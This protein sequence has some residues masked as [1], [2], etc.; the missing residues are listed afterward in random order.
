MSRR[1]KKLPTELVETT[2]ESLSHEGR[3][4]SHIDGKT[5][6]IDNALPGETVR[7]KYKSTRKKFDEGAAQEI[8]SPST[9]RVEPPCQHADMCGGCSLQHIETSFQIQ[10]KENML[11]EQLEHIGHVLP[12]SVLAPLT[13]PT[14]SYR[15]K[16]RLGVKYVVKKEKV[17]VGFREKRSSFLAD[18]DQ[19]EVLHPSVGKLITPLK[20]LITSLSIYNQIPQIEVAVGEKNTVLIFRELEAHTKEDTEKLKNFENEHNISIYIQ[21]GGPDSIVP[22][23]P[24]RESSLSYHFPE[25]DIEMHFSPTDFTQVNFAINRDMV[26][27]VIELLKPTSSDRILDLFCGLGNFTLPLAKRAGHVV[28]VEGEKGLINKAKFNAERNNISN[29][30]FHAMDLAK[31][32]LQASFLKEKY[33]KLLI[34]PP[35]TGAQEIIKQLN[36]KDIDTL[37]YV[38]C[39]PATLAR[40][41]GILVNELGFTLKQ[42]GVMDMFP[43]TAHVESIALF[44]KS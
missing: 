15:Q 35:R 3:G 9:E 13:G 26:K 14:L 25:Y 42:A 40:D 20:E 44:E 31:Q 37:V 2:I 23:S 43:H 18:L 32:D 10:H 11:L 4:I 22:L 30:E 39:N 27:R 29:I 6:F 33:N 5:V 36:L 34:D 16:A 7:F 21:E 17:L 38:S 28:G 12:D 1:R 41:T 8:E 24:E 19:C